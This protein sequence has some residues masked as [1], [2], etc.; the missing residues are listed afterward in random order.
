MNKAI[1]FFIVVEDKQEEQVQ[2]LSAIE[3]VFPPKGEATNFGNFDQPDFWW[4]HTG[5]AAS[6]T[7]V[8]IAKTMIGFREVLR[9][10]LGQIRL[11]VVRR[12]DVLIITDL[13]FPCA[14]GSSEMPNGVSAVLAAV[15]EE[16]VVA[17]CTDTNHHDAQFFK[18]LHP[19]LSE[20]AGYS[21]PYCVD[22]KDWDKA[23]AGVLQVRKEIEDLC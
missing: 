6:L 10:A 15:K 12:E 1:R 11:T 4:R 16:L 9:Q 19:M 22:A 5:D 2:A 14:E 20:K 3:K 23:V 8:W 18:D 17:V 21:I 13:M 7:V